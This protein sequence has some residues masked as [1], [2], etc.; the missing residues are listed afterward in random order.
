MEQM[1]TIDDPGG[2]RSISACM[3]SIGPVTLIA[4][5]RFQSDNDTSPSRLRIVMPA[6]LTR[7]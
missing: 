6:L 3:P 1:L 4:R 7:P 2:I 5:V